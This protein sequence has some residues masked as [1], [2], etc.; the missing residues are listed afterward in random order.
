MRNEYDKYRKILIAEHGLSEKDA[1]RVI[2]L[3]KGMDDKKGC[4]KCKIK[5]N[6]EKVERPNWGLVKGHSWYRY[7]CVR[8]GLEVSNEE[9]NAIGDTA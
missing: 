4:S 7:T 1:E 8:C 5:M 3:H 2:R 9:P 6:R